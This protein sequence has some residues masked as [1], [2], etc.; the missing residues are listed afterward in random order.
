MSVFTQK[1]QKKKMKQTDW[2]IIYHNYQGLEKKAV[3][4]LS[5]EAGKYLIRIND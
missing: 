2:K 4:F 5:N 1:A 3:D